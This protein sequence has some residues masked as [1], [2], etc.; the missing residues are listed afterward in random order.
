MQVKHQNIAIVCEKI[1][2]DERIHIQ[3]INKSNYKKECME[4][5]ML[6]SR[7]RRP[8]TGSTRNMSLTGQEG[9]KFRYVIKKTNRLTKTV[10]A[11]K[12]VLL[13]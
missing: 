13:I 11:K 2:A 3:S 5:D 1:C 8:V 12:I 10:G 9:S 4:R 7:L 6:T